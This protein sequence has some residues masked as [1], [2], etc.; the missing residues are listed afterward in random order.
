MKNL[1]RI[2]LSIL[3]MGLIIMTLTFMARSET[4]NEALLSTDAS[5]QISSVV[6]QNGCCKQWD[7]NYRN[8]R[9]AGYDFAQCEM[10]NKQYDNDIDDLYQPSGRFWWDQY[11]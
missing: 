9:I 11:C 1:L 8:W 6:V 10:W 7:D 5:E 3:A 2:V 4:T